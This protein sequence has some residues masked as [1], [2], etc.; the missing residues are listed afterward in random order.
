MSCGT[1]I[2][3]S[4]STSWSNLPKRV[5]LPPKQLQTT[6]KSCLCAVWGVISVTAAAATGYLSTSR[7][8]LDVVC[9]ADLGLDALQ[10]WHG[11]RCSQRCRRAALQRARG[12]GRGTHHRHLL[13]LVGL[14]RRLRLASGR[15]WSA[16]A[17]LS[18]LGILNSWRRDSLDVWGEGSNREIIINHKNENIQR[19]LLAKSW[20][21][22]ILVRIRLWRCGC[23]RLQ[24]LSNDSCFGFLT[25]Y[26]CHFLEWEVS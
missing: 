15:F 26:L 25:L 4:G 9:G 2:E 5:F 14:G 8:V 18:T 12:L 23:A 13:H 16:R 22:L 1:V 21:S 10:V 6:L 11:R 19:A 7:L 24:V 20:P 17:A 3:A